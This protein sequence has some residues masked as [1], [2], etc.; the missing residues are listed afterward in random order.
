[1]F[2]IRGSRA[3][4]QEILELQIHIDLRRAEDDVANL[5]GKLGQCRDNMVKPRPLA[6]DVAGLEL[7]YDLREPD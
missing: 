2:P 7:C 3:L 4:D 6:S 5:R 1:M